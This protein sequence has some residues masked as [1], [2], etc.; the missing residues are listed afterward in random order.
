MTRLFT[1]PVFMDLCTAFCLDRAGLVGTDGPTHHGAFDYAY[2]RCLPN[3]CVMAPKDEN[4]LQHMIRTAIEYPHP[5]AIRYAR[6]STIGVE[7][8][9]EIGILPIGTGEIVRE[10]QDLAIISIGNMV[11]SSLQAA[12]RLLKNRI[13]AQV[14]NARFVQP[15]DEKLIC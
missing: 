1:T 8:D 6:G 7:M 13:D 2:L 4:E 5:A 10:G 12:D 15:I 14:I 3:M 9:L 11:Y